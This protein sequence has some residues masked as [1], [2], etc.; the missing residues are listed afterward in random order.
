VQVRSGHVGEVG[1]PHH[2]DPEGG[3]PL[4]GVCHVRYLEDR[5]VPA[6]GAETIEIPAG[7]RAL[8]CGRDHL[9]EGV[10]HGEDAIDK[11]ELSDTRIPKR[12][13]GTEIPLQPLQ[14][15]L[16]LTGH[17]SHLTQADKSWHRNQRY[18]PGREH[19]MWL[20][21]RPWAPVSEDARRQL[22]DR[23]P[24]GP[25][26]RLAPMD[27]L[28]VVPTY[29]E[30]ENIS[31]VL[32]RIAAAAPDVDI[33]IV[34]DDSPD[35]TADVAEATGSAIEGLYVLRR[36]ERSGLGNAYRAGFAWGL[37]RGAQA[38]VQ[39]DA[40]LSH[41]PAMV[42]TLLAGLSD[43]DL[44]IGS[45]YVP[46]GS[47]THWSRHRRLLSQTANGYA[48]LMLGLD[49]HDVTAGFRAYRSETLRAIDLDRVR[50]DGYGFQIEMTYLATRA[51]ARVLEVPISFVDRE[52]GQSKMSGVII[53]EA[54][55][56]VTRWGLARGLGKLR[57]AEPDSRV[58]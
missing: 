19:S 5:H 53:V 7:G 42:P 9:D 57:G 23:P 18:W 50:A 48:R 25:P 20:H 8:S 12:R 56:L 43:Y 28:V 4:P 27:T 17:Q 32:E 51:G 33:L 30:A 14:D 10:A 31:T 58:V 44:V 11:P 55:T 22:P 26:L 3:H 52:R 1:G 2:P 36:K 29:N 46:G 6:V 54:M 45:R 34:D 15:R 35:G 13:S 49:V 24:P 39:M 21:A 38:L 40:D 16:E 41:D 37:E 47:V